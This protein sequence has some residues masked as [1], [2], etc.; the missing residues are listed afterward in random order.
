MRRHYYASV[1]Y[2]DAQVGKILTALEKSGQKENTIII[3]W[4]DHGWNLG[5]HSIWGKHNLYEESLHA[6]LII[7]SHGMKQAGI[8]S[9]EI[10]ET[11]DIFPTLC[12]LSAISAPEG[13]HGTSLKPQLEDPESPTDGVA[14]SFWKKSQSVRTDKYR[15]TRQMKNGKTS[16]NLFLFPETKAPDTDQVF[17]VSRE[18]SG[19]FVK[20]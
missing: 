9:T 4:G 11:A 14:I 3:L 19:K 16:Y 13:L 20:E 1:S 10:V 17:R 7:S 8:P 18:L 12:E 15:L 2:V 6:P 5:E